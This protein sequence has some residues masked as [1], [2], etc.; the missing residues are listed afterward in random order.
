MRPRGRKR[1]LQGDVRQRQLI[2]ALVDLLNDGASFVDLSIEDIAKR[3]GITRPG[4][5]FYFTSK[6]EALA[7]ATTAIQQQQYEAARVFL[8]GDSDDP[9]RELELCLLAVTRIRFAHRPIF[10]A[11]S[12]AAAVDQQA[13]RALHDLVEAYVPPISS[14]I[15]RIRRDRG[16]SL[17]T[18]EAEEM[19][20]ALVWSNERN[21]YRAT[22]EGY[23]ETKWNEVVKTLIAIWTGGVL[24]VPREKRVA[25]NGERAAARSAARVARSRKR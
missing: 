1:E 22:V 13:W 21:L 12:D 4:F 3:A 14:R 23:S 25:A 6:E 15:L 5:Y 11:I 18:A 20:R 16:L 2:A 17:S 19:A 8:D 7:A 9:L 24:G 10:R